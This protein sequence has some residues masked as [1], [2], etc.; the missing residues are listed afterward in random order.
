MNNYLELFINSFSDFASYMWSEITFQSVPLYVN[1][2]WLLISLSLVVW[3][4]EMI[5]PWRE[6]QSFIRKDFWLD[7]FYMFFNFYL[8]KLIIFISVSNVTEQVFKDLFNGNIASFA[9]LDVSSFSPIVQL[10][11][12]FIATDFIQ[13][14][15]HVLL[16]KYKILWEFHKVH[17]SVEQMGF[18][19]H[20]RYHWMENIFYTPMKYL[21]VMLI[22]GFQV[23]HVFICYYIAIVIGHLNHANINITWGPLK[24]IVNSPAMHI[25]HHAEKM[26]EHKPEGINFGISLSFWDYLFRTAWVPSSGKNIRLGFASLDRFPNS[27][28]GQLIYPFTKSNK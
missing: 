19:A 7:F 26:P 12:F 14:F 18:A 4:L 20:L 24:Y 27:F 16:H 23:D 22:G 25:W 1:Y 13:W 17:H 9:I 8:F 15:T 3:C 6:K 10:L 5:F 11:I 28:F 21:A 2:F